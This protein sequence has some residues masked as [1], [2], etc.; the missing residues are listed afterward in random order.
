MKPLTIIAVGFILAAGGALAGIV[1]ELTIS[2]KQAAPAA[3][4]A[5]M[6]QARHDATQPLPLIKF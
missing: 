4:T 2:T 1:A 6:E 5:V 3:P